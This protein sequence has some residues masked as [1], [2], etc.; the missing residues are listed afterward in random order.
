MAIQKRWGVTHKV[1][2]AVYA[3]IR[4]NASSGR[5]QWQ[6]A[7][8]LTPWQC[9]AAASPCAPKDRNKNSWS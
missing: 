7:V 5:L 3:D 6:L 9:Y 4:N 1:N 8:L 2:H